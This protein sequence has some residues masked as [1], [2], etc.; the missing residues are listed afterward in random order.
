MDDFLRGVIGLLVRGLFECLVIGLGR[1]VLNLCGWR[2]PHEV[3]AL[4]VGIPVLAIL[5]IFAAGTISRF[6]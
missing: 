2:Q 5:V 1:R 6:L 3:V 4:L